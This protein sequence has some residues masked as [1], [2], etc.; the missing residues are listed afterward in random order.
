MLRM[1]MPNSDAQIEDTTTPP[2]SPPPN[3]LRPTPQTV[4]AA[5]PLAPGPTASGSSILEALA[6][7]ARQNT[8]S[9]PSNSALPAPAA[10][11]SMPAANLPQ[12]V[13]S[14]MPQQ[15]QQQ[16]SSYSSSAQ[17][18]N[19]SSLPFPLSQLQPGGLPN[20]ANALNPYGGGVTAAGPAGASASS[21]A[22]G[23]DQN[24]Q[25]QI[26][27]IKAL[28]DQGVPFDKIP[29]LIQSMTGSVG[30]GAVGSQASASLA[31][32]QNP[33]GGSQ[34][35]WLA[36]APGPADGHARA[37]DDVVRSPPR[38]GRTRSR[39]PD[40]EWGGRNSPRGGRE[41]LEHGRDSPRGR[42]GDRSDGR[43]GAD[44]R[45]RSP[46]RRY[47]HSPSPPED[48]PRIE[49]WVEYDSSLPSGNIKVLSRTLFVGGVTYGFCFFLP[50]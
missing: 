31:T 19:M 1:S 45:Q 32:G 37:H 24:T 22:S 18:V 48:L 25:Q 20:S 46:Q 44:Y 10:S 12:P 7:I 29:A 39:S 42:H 30:N 17:P 50:E 41:S 28:A 14:F 21:G 36:S 26:L 16:Q 11:Y 38:Y 40:R 9:A 47:D 5:A 15:P 13:S 33:Y 27:L 34:F 35:P 43:R 3:P 8:T 23:L 4:G 2:G 49:K 6:N